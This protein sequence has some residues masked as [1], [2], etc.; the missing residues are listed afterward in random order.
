[1]KKLLLGAVCAMFCTTVLIQSCK[2]SK[3]R[4]Y[5]VTSIVNGKVITVIEGESVSIPVKI[6]D[7]VMVNLNDSEITLH[8]KE[9]Q[10]LKSSIDSTDIFVVKSSYLINKQ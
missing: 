1:M 10:T 2:E 7:S 9:L 8:L 3:L 5:D 6:G 4:V